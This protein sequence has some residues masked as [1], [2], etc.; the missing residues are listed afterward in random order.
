MAMADPATRADHHPGT[1]D[2]TADAVR[3]AQIDLLYRAPAFLLINLAI[4]AI[5]AA[6]LWPVYPTLAIVPWLALMYLVVAIRFLDRRRYLSL[7]GRGHEAGRWGRRFVLGAA[8]TGCLWGLAASVLLLTPDFEYHVFVFYLLAGVAA[9]ATV[10]HA[11]HVPAFVGFIIPTFAPLLG[12]TLVR[13]GATSPILAILLAAFVGLLVAVGLTINRWMVDTTRLQI[14]RTA[15]ASDLEAASAELRRRD[16]ILRAMVGSATELLRT[17]DLERSMP[18][19]LKVIGEST[20]VSRVYLY[21]NSRSSDG[22]LMTSKYFEWRAAQ[23]PPE[24]ARD[25]PPTVDFEAAGLGA[26]ERALAHGEAQTAIV[27]LLEGPARDLFVQ[28][29]TKSTLMVPVLTQGGW[30]G[31][32][33]FDDCETER[34]WSAAEIDTLRTIAE[35]AGAA[36]GHARDLDELTTAARIVEHSAT[37]LYRLQPEPPYAVTYIS[38]NAARYGY[39]LDQFLSQPSFYASLIH[40]DDRPKVMHDLLRVAEH[41]ETVSEYRLRHPDGSYVWFED[42]TRAIRDDSGQLT[43]I[44][45]LITDINDHKAAEAKISRFELTDQLTGLANRKSFMEH[46]AHAFSATK[47]GAAPFAILYLDLDLFKDVNDALGHSKGDELLKAVAGRLKELCRASDV[48]ARFGGD[49]FAML[50]TDAPDPAAAG[51]LAARILHALS[52]PYDL[53]AEIHVTASLGIAVYD[54]DVAGPEALLQRADLALYRAKDAGRN[55]YHFHS[56]ALDVE[57]RERVTLGEEL[58]RALGRHELELYYQPQIEAPSGTIKGFEALVRW[59]HPVQGLLLPGRFIPIAEK[60]GT[61]VPIGRWVVD[62]ACRQVALWRAEIPSLPKVSI[63]LSAAQ[64][65]PSL[66]F[67][68]E[69]RAT[70]QKYGLD[71]SAIEFELT[72]S[73]L[74]QTTRESSEMIERLR[75]LGVSIAIDDFGTG[76]SSLEYLRTYHVNHIKI[77]QEFVRDLVTDP[78]DAAIVRATIGLARELGIEVIAEGVETAEQLHFLVRAGCDIIQG[79]YFSPAVPASQVAPMLIKGRLEPACSGPGQTSA[80]TDAAG[81]RG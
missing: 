65:R 35:L 50:Q 15:L 14:A 22:G 3:A 39:Q 47:R 53:G 68:G 70:L 75:A 58:H 26:W 78:G 7:S 29:G 19:V 61:I 56:E 9:A 36:I 6:V 74:M 73:V 54:T 41:G 13:E 30:W 79:Y 77:A 59:N 17:F 33:G 43:A 62:D 31:Q 5:A 2:G 51:A 55:Q 71:A 49:E 44:E 46:L 34:R 57:V 12:A 1:D 11:A 80:K 18:A 20:N 67:D 48:V 45:G 21:R 81:T 52:A 37:I 69:F 38:R 8:A 32:M 66:D 10:A 23:V 25:L 28:Y 27:R 63:N 24:A 64:L 72:E 76:Y 16:A 40:P 60:T 4:A 42:R